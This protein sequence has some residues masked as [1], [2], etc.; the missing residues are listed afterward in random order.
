[1]ENLAWQK[2][3][4]NGGKLSDKERK[5]EMMKDYQKGTA[6][7][8]ICKKYGGIRRDVIYY[9]LINN[10]IPRKRVIQRRG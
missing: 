10:S 2:R 5:M 3:S 7:K 4:H 8:D 9:H 6:L 1:M